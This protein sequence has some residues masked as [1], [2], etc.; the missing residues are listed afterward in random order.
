MQNIGFVFQYERYGIQIFISTFTFS[1]KKL[2]YVHMF[3]SSILLRPENE[4]SP[5]RINLHVIRASEIA[6]KEEQ[7]A[8]RP[9]VCFPLHGC[10]LG[11]SLPALY[12]P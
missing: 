10:P 5:W 12:W 7:N 3:L 4:L 1:R 9:I 2:G 11:F 6:M 8:H